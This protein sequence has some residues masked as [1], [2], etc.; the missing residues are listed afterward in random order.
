MAR[1][2]IKLS[3]NIS[4]C[5]PVIAKKI[6]GSAYNKEPE[7]LAFNNQKVVVVMYPKEINLTHL[8]NES[9]ARQVLD[10]LK[11]ILNDTPEEK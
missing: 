4:P 11:N 10:W 9:H 5:L 8:E 7:Q 1:A 2:V 6:K 3:G